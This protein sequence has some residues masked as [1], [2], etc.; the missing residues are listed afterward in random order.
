MNLRIWALLVC[1]LV[2]TPLAAQLPFYTDDP[3]VTDKGKLHFEFFNEYD[4]LQ[5]AQYP[6]L[7]QNTAN[8]KLNY[9]LPYRLELDIDSPYLSIFHAAGV[10]T[11]NGVGDTNLG[12]KW[13]FRRPPENS[14]SLALAASLYVEFPTGDQRRQ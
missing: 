3:A 10:L 14:R 6:D 1:G 12:V 7:R 8:Y 2:T 11:A 4:W 13:N 5:N 9:G